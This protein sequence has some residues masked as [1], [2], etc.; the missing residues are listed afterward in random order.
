M[1]SS[2][3]SQNLHKSLKKNL[4]TKPWGLDHDKERKARRP[5]PLPSARPPFELPIRKTG[6]PPIQICKFP[7]LPL[8]GMIRSPSLLDLITLL[9]INW[10]LPCSPPLE[11]LQTRLSLLHLFGVVGRWSDAGLPFLPPPP[12]TMH[13]SSAVLVRTYTGL[14]M[15][16]GCRVDLGVDLARPHGYVAWWESWDLHRSQR[17]AISHVVLHPQT[18]LILS[19]HRFR[20]RIDALRSTFIGPRHRLGSDRKHWLDPL[21]CVDADLCHLRRKACSN[22]SLSSQD[23]MLHGCDDVATIV[24]KIRDCRRHGWERGC[25][26]VIRDEGARRASKGKRKKEIK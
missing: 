11:P 8:H 7:P 22:V 18:R 13:V 20:R 2:H 12:T 21:D 19:G 10:I 9:P 5:H 26:L 3:F 17:F 1:S 14:S 16:R 23:C 6:F 15:R 24:N 25:A 4:N